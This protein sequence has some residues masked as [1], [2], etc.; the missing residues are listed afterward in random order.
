MSPRPPVREQSR[1]RVLQAPTQPTAVILPL[2]LTY[3]FPYFFSLFIFGLLFPDIHKN[4]RRE[5][6]CVQFTALSHSPRLER[7]WVSVFFFPL[8]VGGAGHAQGPVA[9]AY[10]RQVGNL[11][12]LTPKPRHVAVE[13]SL[14]GSYWGTMG[15]GE[16]GQ[17]VRG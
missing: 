17:A 16:R 14:A 15:Y 5:S 6:I 3:L 7:G 9:S 11:E 10:G 13:S 8:A 1:E 4:R 12:R 2:P